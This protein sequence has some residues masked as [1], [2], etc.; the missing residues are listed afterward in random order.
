MSVAGSA[1]P[2]VRLQTIPLWRVRA[3][4]SLTRWVLY[5]TTAVGIVATMRFAISP[6]HVAAPPAPHVEARDPAAEAFASLFARSYLTWD[7]ANPALHEQA[8]ASF[9]GSEVDPDAGMRPA[10]RGAENVLWAQVAQERAVGPGEH[11]YT[12]AAQTDAAG[13]V[14]LAV[15]VARDSD[16]RLRIGR[17]PAFAGAPLVRPTNALGSDDRPQLTD[18]VVATVVSRALTNYL[19]GSTANLDADLAAGAVVASPARRLTLD[20]VEALHVVPGGGALATVMAHDA[21]GSRFTLDYELDL[22]RAG[23]RWEIV[24]IETDPTA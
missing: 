18:P 5:A 4:L 23:G 16:G 19:A 24:A 17:Y 7:A 22:V 15:D 13:L 21:L 8:L 10:S 6:P 9:L 20:S 3:S 14:Y 2:R 11:V 1:V 12:V